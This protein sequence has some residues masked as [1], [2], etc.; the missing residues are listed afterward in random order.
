V[1]QCKSILIPLGSVDS[2]RILYLI[3]IVVGDLLVGRRWSSSMDD[4]D[5]NT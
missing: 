1:V 4:R 3:P 2:I 5:G